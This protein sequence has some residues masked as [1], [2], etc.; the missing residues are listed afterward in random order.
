LNGRVLGAL[1]KLWLERQRSD[2]YVGTLV[3]EYIAR[4]GQVRAERAGSA[5]FDVGTLDGYRLAMHALD[6]GI[7]QRQRASNSTASP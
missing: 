1:Y 6:D 7:E 5:Y 4:G 2:A 3:N